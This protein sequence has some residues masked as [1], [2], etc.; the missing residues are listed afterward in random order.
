MPLPLTVSCFSIIQIGF[1]S[2]VPAHLGS[3]EKKAIKRVYVGFLTLLA[4]CV[5]IFML[6]LS[7]N[8][9]DYSGGFYIVVRSVC[10]MNEVSTR[11]ARLMPAWVTVFEWVYCLV[12]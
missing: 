6:L 10:H 8:V 11:R 1:T 7:F 9:A 3:P 5:F 12:M 4:C 2:V